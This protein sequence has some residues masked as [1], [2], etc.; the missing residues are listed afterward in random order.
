VRLSHPVKHPGLV[1][2]AGVCVP[3]IHPHFKTID[4]CA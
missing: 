2:N 1:R 3:S 4:V